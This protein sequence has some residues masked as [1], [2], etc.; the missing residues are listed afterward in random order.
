MKFMKWLTVVGIQWQAQEP[1]QGVLAALGVEADSLDA[2]AAA[3]SVAAAVVAVAAV[4]PLPPRKS[5]AYQPDPLSWKPAAVSCLLKASA[6][7][8]GHVVST[9]SEI[10]CKTSLAWPQDAHL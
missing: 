8:A 3:G 5:V 6:P 4:P 7:Q 9:A 2:G 10:F 1:P